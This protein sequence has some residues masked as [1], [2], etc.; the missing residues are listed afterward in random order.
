MAVVKIAFWS[1]DSV[2]EWVFLNV[3]SNYSVVTTG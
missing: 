1:L 2:I 3:R